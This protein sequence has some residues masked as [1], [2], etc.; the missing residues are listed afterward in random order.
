MS[1][2]WPPSSIMHTPTYVYTHLHTH[3]PDIPEC[4]SS[5]RSWCQRMLRIAHLFPRWLAAAG[6]SG[7][8]WHRAH[9]WRAA[10]TPQ[11]RNTHHRGVSACV[12]VCVCVCVCACACVWLYNDLNSGS[13]CVNMCL[14]ALACVWLYNDLI[15]RVCVFVCVCGSA[16][17]C[18]HACL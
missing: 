8:S 6:H 4:P 13:V 5:T 9:S 2:W 11:G 7:Q 15:S 18:M 16:C 12:G 10:A 17:A 1:I 14:C 3:V